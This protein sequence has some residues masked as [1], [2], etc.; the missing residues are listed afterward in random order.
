MAVSDKLPYFI[1]MYN[2]PSNI[3]P[4]IRPA[5]K[6]LNE[7]GFKT[8]E[9]C[10]GGEGH[11]FLEPTIRFE[12]SEFDLIRAYEICELHGLP[13]M[14]VRRVYR[15]T[16]IHIDDN[17]PSVRQIGETWDKPFDEIIFLPINKPFK[18]Q[19]NEQR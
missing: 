4:L 12:G 3:D 6:I 14:E 16:P 15:K 1:Y 7:H 5:V 2:L 18:K 17:T 9:S 13:V 10:Q 19:S 11:A 8:F